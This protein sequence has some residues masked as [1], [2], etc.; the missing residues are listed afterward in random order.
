VKNSTHV[1]IIVIRNNSYLLGR[2]HHDEAA[3]AE[4]A[5]NSQSLQ[6]YSGG[7]NATITDYDPPPILGK[8]SIRDY[9]FLCARDPVFTPF[10]IMLAWR[11]P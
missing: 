10:I 1:P 5:I 8:P 11:K 2:F 7:W 9:G 3:P 4:G 6:L